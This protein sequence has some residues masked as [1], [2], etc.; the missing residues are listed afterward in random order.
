VNY[1]GGIQNVSHISI[2]TVGSNAAPTWLTNVS[3]TSTHAVTIPAHSSE[4]DI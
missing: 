2:F 1:S 3:L 4:V